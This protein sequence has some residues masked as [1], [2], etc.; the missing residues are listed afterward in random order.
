MTTPVIAQ[1]YRGITNW[2]D[3]SKCL[4]VSQ[5]FN[6]GVVVGISVGV[7]VLLFYWLLRR[8]LRRRTMCEGITI[9]GEH[10]DVFITVNAVYEFVRRIL[11]EFAEASLQS[12]N[13]TQKKSGLSMQVG[14]AVVP[15]TDLVPLRDR[16]QGRIIADAEQRMG[17]TLPLRVHLS[18][19]SLEADEG[20]IARRSRKGNP[21]APNDSQSAGSAAAPDDVESSVI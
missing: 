3:C 13:L 21:D 7:V 11:Y 4:G 5:D 17:I 14:I 2:F 1:A 20:K 18:I 9:T 15:N 12:V 10:G 16:L 8:L 6:D 19:R